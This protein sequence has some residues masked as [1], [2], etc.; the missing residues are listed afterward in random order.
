M[1]TTNGAGKVTAEL[2]GRLEFHPSASSRRSFRV[3]KRFVTDAQQNL[4]QLISGPLCVQ[5]RGG[6][7]GDG[8]C[9]VNRLSTLV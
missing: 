4:L 5:S 9:D 1:N 2:L 3:E 6:R 8:G 7:R